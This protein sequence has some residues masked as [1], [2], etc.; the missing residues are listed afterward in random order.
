ME[1]PEELV[2]KHTR[3]ELDQIAED[4]GIKDPSSLPRKLA[5]A[6]AII[7]KKKAEEY[8]NKPVGLTFD[9]LFY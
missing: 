7:D 3:K 6:K 8:G 1:E 4:M 2:E 5:V 9:L